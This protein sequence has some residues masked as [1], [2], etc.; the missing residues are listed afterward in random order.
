MVFIRI[1]YNT[2]ILI[3]GYV[4]FTESNK[5]IIRFFFMVNIS[6][7]RRVHRRKKRLREFWFVKYISTVQFILH[8]ILHD[9]LE[10]LIIWLIM[11]LVCVC[12]PCTWTRLADFRVCCGKASNALKHLLDCMW[13]SH[14]MSFLILS[15]FSHSKSF[16]FID[17][18][19]F[20]S[21]NYLKCTKAWPFLFLLQACFSFLTDP[22]VSPVASNN[23][24][25]SMQ[26]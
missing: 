23:I 2:W 25:Y 20:S 10:H 17:C 5:I 3:H 24:R 14:S 19:G 22:L 16:K 18:L 1:S 8:F 13:Y 4:E 11:I 9:T 12:T 7:E 26:C 6:E 15:A 21:S